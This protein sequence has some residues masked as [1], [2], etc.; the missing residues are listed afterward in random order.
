M[1][2]ALSPM[3]TR[4]LSYGLMAGLMAG[5]LAAG[6]ALAAGPHPHS[7]KRV[8]KQEI[9]ALEDQWRVAQLA[10]DVATMDKLLAPDYLGI[11]MNGQINDKDQQLDRMRNRTLMLSSIALSDVK[12]KLVGPVAIVTSLAQVEGTS[13]GVVIHGMYRYTRIYR[14]YPDGT[15]KITNF[16][17]TPIAGGKAGRAA[18]GDGQG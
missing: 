7:H 1:V 15:W 16:E 4:A 10:D 3:R 2:R 12:I 17:V 13:D 14:R 11:S 9:V 5:A 18:S 8:F 6:V